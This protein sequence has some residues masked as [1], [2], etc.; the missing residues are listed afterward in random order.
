MQQLTER[1]RQL[2]ESW[3]LAPLV[4]ALQ[5]MRGVELVT[6]VTLAAEV[7]TTDGSRRR[8]TSWATWD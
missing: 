6:A 5:A 2:V 8:V 7:E 1:L 4:K 3:R